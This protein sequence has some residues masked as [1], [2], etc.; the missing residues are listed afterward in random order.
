MERYYAWQ[1]A[2]AVG[3]TFCSSF[4]L[5][6]RSSVHRPNRQA[7]QGGEGLQRVE[8][9]RRDMGCCVLAAC[10]GGMW[11]GPEQAWGQG[12]PQNAAPSHQHLILV[13]PPSVL[14]RP[15]CQVMS[16]FITL[17]TSTP[18][19]EP[20]DT[21]HCLQGQVHSLCLGVQSR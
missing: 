6:K 12:A 5:N 14:P 7:E 10:G 21:P 9:G 18:A 16:P 13:S 3:C 20:T 8:R 17:S 4:L 1:A 19:H 15:G 2:P 11:E